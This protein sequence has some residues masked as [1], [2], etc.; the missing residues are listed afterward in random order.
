MMARETIGSYYVEGRLFSMV[1]KIWHGNE[2]YEGL[3]KQ[4]ECILP[5]RT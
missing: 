1:K 3:F 4:N 2:F 5:Q